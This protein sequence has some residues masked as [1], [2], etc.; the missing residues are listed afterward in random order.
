MS[1]YKFILI[2]R[3]LL[4]QLFLCSPLNAQDKTEIIP[5]A[6]VSGGSTT[7]NSYGSISYSIG[8]VRYSTIESSDASLYEGIQRPE[9]KV[10]EKN[11]DIEEESP[12]ST[13]KIFPNPFRDHFKI[14]IEK[15]LISNSSYKLYD[16]SGKIIHQGKMDQPITEV[17]PRN[18][19][20]AIYIL[21]LTDLKG[22]NNSFKIIKK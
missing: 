17:Y 22:S 1:P 8:Q 15:T 13:A 2:S 3:L 19:P 14:I 20:N 6:I 18:I 7:T 10:K 9:S 12:L 16:L 21:Q 5:I 4:V 11:F